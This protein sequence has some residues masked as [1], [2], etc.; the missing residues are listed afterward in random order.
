MDFE[1]IL[2]KASVALIAGAYALFVEAA[3]VAQAQTR[4]IAHAEH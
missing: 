4:V 3:S 2:R 1:S